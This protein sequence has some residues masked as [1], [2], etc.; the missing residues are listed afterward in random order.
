M[1]LSLRRLQAHLRTV[2][3]SHLRRTTSSSSVVTSPD[4]TNDL[5]HLEALG[6]EL[7]ELSQWEKD[8]VVTAAERK[9]Q[10]TRLIATKMPT[11]TNLPWSNLVLL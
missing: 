7:S 10:A 2:E 6:H 1:S 4:E 3:G 8:G 9:T 11:P 5:A